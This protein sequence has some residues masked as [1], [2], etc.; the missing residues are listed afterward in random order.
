MSALDQSGLTAL[1]EG[2]RVTFD[3]TEGRKGPEAVKVRLV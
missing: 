1:N 2:D 3:V